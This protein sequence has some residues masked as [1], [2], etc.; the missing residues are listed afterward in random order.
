MRPSAGPGSLSDEWKCVPAPKRGEL[1][2]VFGDMLRHNKSALGALVTPGV[3][4]DPPGR[5][6]RGAGDDRYLRFRPGSVAPVVR[7]DHRF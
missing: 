3:R 6:G 4:K 7:P 2:R 5:A 1:I